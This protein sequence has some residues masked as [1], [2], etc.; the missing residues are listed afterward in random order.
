[1]DLGFQGCPV[2]WWNSREGIHRVWERLDWGVCTREWLELFPRALIRHVSIATS[3]HLALVLGTRGSN[4]NSTKKLRLFRFEK[5]WV[6]DH[7]CE[8]VIKQ[9]CAFSIE[10]TH[11]F[12]VCQKIKESRL[13][14]LNCSRIQGNGR[15]R[16]IQE[17]KEKLQQCESNI[18]E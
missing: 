3:N 7:M 14:L 2:T 11:M 12:K 16:N 5:S 9:A 15:S 8:E 13:H 1:M 6:K 17:K 10:G 4:T 18:E